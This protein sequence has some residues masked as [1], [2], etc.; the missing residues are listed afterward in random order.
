MQREITFW[1]ANEVFQ[2]IINL[3]WACRYT[4]LYCNITS[5]CSQVPIG[6]VGVLSGAQL[7][8][9]EASTIIIIIILLQGMINT[10]HHLLIYFF[11]CQRERERL[12]K[13]RFGNLNITKI[14]SIFH[15]LPERI[16]KTTVWFKARIQYDL[17]TAPGWRGMFTM[18]PCHVVTAGHMLYVHTDKRRLSSCYGPLG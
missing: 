6:V 17:C 7:W 16:G 8:G 14:T 11:L 1:G 13:F 4:L 2:I 5:M 9:V 15:H 3:Q 18:T 10:P 12:P